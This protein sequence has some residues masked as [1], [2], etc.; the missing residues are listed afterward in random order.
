MKKIVFIL[1]ALQTITLR[2]QF[3]DDFSDG[4]FQ[5]A[6]HAPRPVHWTGDEAEFTINTALQLQLRSAAG[7]SPVQLRTPSSLV[8]NTQWEWEM[9]LDFN[10]SSSNYA[11]VYLASDEA[12][13]TAPLN[14]LFVRIGYTDRNICLMQ[15]K[16]GS[17]NKTLIAGEKRRLDVAAPALSLRATLDTHGNF[18]LYS[19]LGAEVDF[20][21]E[22]SC[23]LQEIPAAAWFGLVCYFTSTRRQHFFFD[24]FKVQPLDDTPPNPDPDPDFPRE[25]D[26]VFTEIMANPGSAS[27]YPEYIELY[28][29]T[30]KTFRLPD[31]LLYYGDRAY[32]LPA[33]A[34]EPHTYFVLCKTAAVDALPAGANAAGVASF[35][36]LANA[37]K[38]L[39]LGNTENE[40]V[41]WFEYSDAMYRDAA[42][43][44]GGWS[45]ECIDPANVSNTDVNWSAAT[46]PSGGTPGRANS[47]CASN[48]DTTPPAL[49]SVSFSEEN[50][51]DIVFSKPMNRQ[52]LA[53][54]SS[55]VLRSPAYVLSDL[56]V[57]YPQATELTLRLQPFP[58]AGEI[59]E[60]AL[61]GVQDRSGNEW[62]AEQPILIG[63]AF[64]ALPGDLVIN[65]ILFNPPAGGNEYVELYNRSDKMLDLRHLSITS[66][67]PSDGSF[68]TAYPL[69][70]LPV[71]LPPQAYVVVTKDRARVCSFFACREESLFAEPASLPSLA[72][73]GGCAVILNNR[74]NAIVDE[75]YYL[76]SMHSKLLSGSKKGIALERIHYDLP[77]TAA[78]NWTSAA[79]SSGYGTPG[80]VNSQYATTTG[81]ATPDVPT[82]TVEYPTAGEERYGLRY[83]LDR[84]GY[85]GRL[86]IYDAAGR[87]INI[88]LHNEG[89]GRQGVV[90]WN[91]RGA[92][93]RRLATGIYIVYLE[94][95]DS[96]GE[97]RKLK[98]PLVVR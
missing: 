78:D 25:G 65:E 2:A 76:E 3:S 74:T 69:A 81:I 30:A 9:Q 26:I 80:Y 5:S 20:R 10:P 43:T 50:G 8:S 83:C 27:V 64:E 52:L 40:I 35:P 41:A 94:L 71:F 67:R 60:L 56:E 31:C 45:L 79:A 11:K 54:E 6:A 12:D 72:N 18:H 57:N 68:N 87:L 97:G 66:R 22:G 86:F 46:D 49:R 91:G 84:P 15:S 14:G 73:T 75:L 98:V 19:R 90:Y 13:L 38:L 7:Q 29:T 89:M 92:G 88:L 24:R 96:R 95:F 33:K 42:K 1:L 53:D 39:M 62:P 51:I 16:K 63:H 48:P 61:P 77:S 37:G 28:N 34:I 85:N 32:A 21:L 59:I 55:Y 44:S 23:H 47:I 70:A 4:R 58:P 82:L 17:T 36:A 93:G